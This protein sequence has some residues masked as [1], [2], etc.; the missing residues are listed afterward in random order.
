VV[1]ESSLEATQGIRQDDPGERLRIKVTNVTG[2]GLEL[3][4]FRSP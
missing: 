2:V 4:I 3:V 1:G